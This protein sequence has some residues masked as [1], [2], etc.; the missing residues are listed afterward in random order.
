LVTGLEYI[1][2]C[3]E[4]TDKGLYV[5][6]GSFQCH[7]FLD[8]RF[9]KGKQWDNLNR[10]LG[11]IGIPSVQEK[12]DE[13]FPPRVEDNSESMAGI[14]IEKKVRKK[15]KAGMKTRKNAGT[16]KSAGSEKASSGIEKSS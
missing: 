13:L 2:S 3:K 6:L 14:P 7:V 16:K 1:R 10:I 12:F 9:V 5:E 8:W 4:L 11:G 15:A